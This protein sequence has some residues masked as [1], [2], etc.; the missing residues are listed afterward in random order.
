ML[1]A[2]AE[3][4]G[5]VPT[6]YILSTNINCNSIFRAS[7]AR[8]GFHEHQTHMVHTHTL[9]QTLVYIEMKLSKNCN[10][11]PEIC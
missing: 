8:S 9:R 1:T 2:L 10:I 4:P 3:N 7:D 11:K 6:I 5:S